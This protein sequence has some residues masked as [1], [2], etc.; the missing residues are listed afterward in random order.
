MMQLFTAGQKLPQGLRKGVAAIG[1]FDGLHRGHQALIAQAKARAKEL[2]TPAGI[3]TFEPHPR[4]FFQPDKPLFR[5][6]PPALKLELAARLGL[7][8]ALVMDF[9]AGL[10]GLSPD[11]FVQ[12]AIVESLGAAHVVTGYDFRFGKNRAGDAALLAAIGGQ[13]GF[14][15]SVVDAVAEGGE[16]FSSSAIRS[17]L[18]QGRMEEAARQLGYWWRIAG[19]VVQGDQRGRTIGYPTANVALDPGMEAAEGIYAARVHVAGR[20]LKGAAYI[21]ARPT[22][23]TGRRFLEI[24]LIG[25]SGDIYGERLEAELVSFIRPD[26]K[27]DGLEPLLKQ[28]DDDC[29]EISRRLDGLAKDDPMRGFP[30]GA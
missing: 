6:T 14:G 18:A 25:F 9:N 5:L 13:H 17:L 4:Q 15:V 20:L 23:N 26:R 11:A 29:A 21:G 30:L 10:A 8:F 19:E 22:F 28:M 1:N 12:A 2:G 24:H 7:D 16:A 27:F 3:L